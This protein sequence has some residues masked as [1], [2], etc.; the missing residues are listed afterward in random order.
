M[1]PLAFLALV[2]AAPAASPQLL[3]GRVPEDAS[4]SDAAGPESCLGQITADIRH[5]EYGF[6]PLGSGV[7]SAPNRAQDLRSRVSAHGLEVF[8]RSTGADGERAPWRLELRTRSFGRTDGEFEL[9]P[10]ALEVRGERAELDHGPLVE[11]LENRT[12]GI[13]QGWTIA[14]RPMG[15]EPLWIGLDLEGDLA[16]RIDEGRRSGTL[17]DSCGETCLRYTGL[18]AFDA[19][20][21]ELEARLLPGPGGVGILVEDA[22]ATYPLTVD[23]L[24]TGGWTAESDQAGAE[25]GFAVSTAGDVNGDGYSDVIVGA[26]YYDNGQTDEGRAFVYHG[27]A[28]GLGSSPAWTAEGDQAS[29]YFGDSVSTAGDVNG[30][31]YSDVVVGA[32]DYDNG[33]D[34]NEGRAYVYHG[35]VS[36]LATSPA[37]TAVSNQAFAGFGWSV[38][39]AGDVNGDG[40][41]EVIVGAALYDNGQTDEGR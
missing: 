15:G 28:S 5:A 14:A 25:F 33:P 29:A 12:D 2:L 27:S 34:V 9:G 37:W 38:S 18:R 32:R 20:R 6:S 10:A 41:S 26:F 21:R 31:G 1:Q 40:Y 39:T 8:P 30:D 19:T 17:V 22:G 16:L 35:S 11:W 24:L 3:P 23:P 13:E 4:K 7:F 36:G